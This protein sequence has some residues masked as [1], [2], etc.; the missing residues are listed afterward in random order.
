VFGSAQSKAGIV[1]FGDSHAAQ[2]FPAL[3]RI[4]IEKQWKL[5]SLTK[6]SCPPE[7]VAVYDR[8][9]NRD[10]YE[11]TEWRIAAVRRIIDLHPAAVV[12]SS[13]SEFYVKDGISPKLWTEGLRYTLNQ[14][15]RAGIRV[16]LIRDPPSPLFDVRACLARAAWMNITDRCLFEREMALN[17]VVSQMEVAV[18]NSVGDASAVDPSPL[19]CRTERCAPLKDGIILYRDQNH[20]TAS[21]VRQL[22]PLLRSSLEALMERGG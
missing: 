8:K 13:Y 20:L 6:S 3:E 17:S 15:S 7:R 4:A 16:V 5:I 9:L 14:F 21:Y 18:V 10:Y 19:I 2:W 22:T 1:L 12:L 11:C